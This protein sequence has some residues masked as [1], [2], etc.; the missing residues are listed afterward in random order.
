SPGSDQC[1]KCAVPITIGNLEKGRSVAQDEASRAR[2]SQ[3]NRV[4]AERVRDWKSSELPPWLTRELYSSKIVPAL[5]TLSKAQI[6]SALGIS[7]PWAA[8]IQQGARVPHARHWIRLAELVGVS[9]P[10]YRPHHW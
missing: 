9:S 6:R 1:E 4:Q 10:R 7:E 2:R 5:A 3:T 8:Y